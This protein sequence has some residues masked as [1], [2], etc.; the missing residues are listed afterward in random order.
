MPRE[1]RRFGKLAVGANRSFWDVSDWIMANRKSRA[2]TARE[3]VAILERGSYEHPQSGVVDI[4]GLV[5]SARAETVLYRPDSFKQVFARRDAILAKKTRRE[6]RFTVVNQTTLAAARELV[7]EQRIAATAA[8]N[9]ASAKNP[10]GGFLGG[11]RAQEESLARASGLYACISPMREMYDTNRAQRSCLYTDHMIYSPRVPVIRDDAD[12]LIAE[13][14][15]V[16]FIT[17]PAVN[18]GAVRQNRPEEADQIAPTMHS[19][20][21]KV[22]SL[23]VIHEVEALV[24]GAWGCGVFKNDPAE[25]AAAFRHHLMENRALAG[26][27]AQVVFAVV[28]WSEN[29]KFIGPFERAFP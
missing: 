6:T 2:T 16:D 25:I 28:D 19:R 27:F 13:P 23:A 14:F 24:L 3:T 20:I 7:V 26:A 17:A 18:A 10:G 22:L 8:L 12:E 15:C 29:G 4:A 1:V 9:F 11:S 21:E 5:E